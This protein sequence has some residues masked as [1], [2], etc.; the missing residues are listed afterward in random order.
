MTA[1]AVGMNEAI[2]CQVLGHALIE[3]KAAPL[4]RRRHHVHRGGMG[5]GGLF[6]V[7]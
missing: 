2:A 3:G 5:A 4:Q 7:A 6:E 1:G